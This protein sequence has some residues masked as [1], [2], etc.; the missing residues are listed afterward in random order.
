MPNMAFE[1]D[2]KRGALNFMWGGTYNLNSKSAVR[3]TYHSLEGDLTYAR[4][5]Q[6]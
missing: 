6:A 4:Q 1:R 2:A 5:D 3:T